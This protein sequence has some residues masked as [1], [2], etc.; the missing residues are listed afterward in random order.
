MG[1][2]SALICSHDNKSGTQEHSAG[3]CLGNVDE[4]FAP[5]QKWPSSAYLAIP[6]VESGPLGGRWSRASC[7]RGRAPVKDVG[8]D[9][10]LS[11]MC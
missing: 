8:R 4:I 6:A 11:M 10:A 7:Q 5:N 3:T 1:Q 9:W 2:I